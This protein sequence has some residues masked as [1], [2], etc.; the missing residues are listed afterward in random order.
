MKPTHIVWYLR[1][2]HR[3]G[4]AAGALFF[5]GASRWELAK[6]FHHPSLYV[7]AEVVWPPS[8]KQLSFRDSFNQPIDGVAWPVSLQKRSLGGLF[9]QP[10]TEVEWR[11]SLQ[12]LSFGNVFNRSI[13]LAVWPALLRQLWL[14]MDSTS[15]SPTLCGWPPCN[16]SRLGVHSTSSSEVV[17]L[18]SLRS[19]T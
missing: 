15:L 7:C 4:V 6:L 16:S 5:F 8:L 1:S 12:Q 2:V 10:I 14:G 9:N 13:H 18:A 11:T 3:D 17:W 19:V